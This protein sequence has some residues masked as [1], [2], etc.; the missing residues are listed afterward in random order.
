MISFAI[1]VLVGVV[2]S[3]NDWVFSLAG[4]SSFRVPSFV[5]SCAFRWDE[6]GDGF[7]PPRWRFQEETHMKSQ[8]AFCTI[9]LGLLSLCC[10]AGCPWSNS[11]NLFDG[12]KG[13]SMPNF[14]GPPP[15]SEPPIADES[16]TLDFPRS[17]ADF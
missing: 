17:D 2:K 12:A 16:S 13:I 4:K 3:A 15:Q 9:A 10:L 7:I 8:K 6:E 1:R 5:V 11:A 14:N